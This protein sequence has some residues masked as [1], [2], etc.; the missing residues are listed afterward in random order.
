[1]RRGHP[2]A[3]VWIDVYANLHFHSLVADGIFAVDGPEFVPAAPPTTADVQRV[4]DTVRDKVERLLVRRGL[5][6]GNGDGVAG[7]EGDDA[8]HA[9]L[10]QLPPQCAATGYFNLHAGVGIGAQ[11][12][13]GLERLCRYVLRPPLSRARLTWTEHGNLQIGSNG[14]GMTEPTGC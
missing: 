12:R 3:V 5:V 7:D 13:R 4:V 10:R 14:H 8:H 2:A 6:D 1:M 9:W 11:D